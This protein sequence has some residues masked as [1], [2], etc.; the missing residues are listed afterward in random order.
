MM[1]NETWQLVSNDFQAKIFKNIA[2]ENEYA[3]QET[4]DSGLVCSFSITNDTFKI[5]EMSWAVYIDIDL[6]NKIVTLTS[7]DEKKNG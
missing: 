1:I 3:I 4:N 5:K 6:E 7:S 2:N